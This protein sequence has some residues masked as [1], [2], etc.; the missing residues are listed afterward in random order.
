MQ[1]TRHIGY[2]LRRLLYLPLSLGL[3]TLLCFA[4]MH[5]APGDPVRQRMSTEGIRSATYDVRAYDR[6]Y[7][8]LANTL[9][10]D[11]PLFYFTLSNASLPDTLYRIV[12]PNRRR[13]V[14][15]LALY[16]GN[17]AAVQHY[18][19]TL[20]RFSQHLATQSSQ[21]T[22][23]VRKLLL[24]HEPR[25][26]ADQLAGLTTPAAAPLRE[27]YQAMIDQATPYRTLLPRIYFYGLDNQYHHYISNLLSG[28]LGSSYIDRRPVSRKIAEALP[29]TVL[30]NGLALLLVYLL[31]VP[32]GLYMAYYGGSRFDRWATAITFLAFGIPSFWVAT[33][34]AIFFTTPAFGMDWFP[35]MGYGRPPAT[36]SWLA[37]MRTYVNHL[38][39]PVFCLAY[40]SWAYVSRHLRTAAL[41]EL[42][43]SYV[44]TARM[45]GLAGTQVL[46]NHVFRNASFPLITLL[47]GL[48]PALLAGSVLIE[49]IF[50]LPG[51][52]QLLYSS[53]QARDW[54]VVTA[55]VL[56]NG[57]LTVVGLLLADLGYVLVDPRLRF[58]KSIGR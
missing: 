55:L 37:G 28:D 27:A 39:L 48:L 30:L 3:L 53:A 17:W 29:G 43:K 47:G 31:A 40:P 10:Y 35:S 19:R 24:R 57:L 46:W 21:S 51:M 50:N 15:S 22:A 36:A 42:R 44:T 11:R 13:V 12:D 54:P 20:L 56:T 49:Y 45:K 4:L 16:Y 58:T 25:Q 2:F 9:G 38:I 52:G 18:Y 6:S 8:R 32:L 14:K 7:T 26:I 41:A 1:Q 34:L 5:I 33:L 23:A